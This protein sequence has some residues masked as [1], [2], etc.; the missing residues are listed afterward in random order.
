MFLLRKQEKSFDKGDFVLRLN[1]QNSGR[2][3]EK[4]KDLLKIL[5]SKTIAL[6]SLGL[7]PLLN[8]ARKIL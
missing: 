7:P 2:T 5:Q 3:L 6:H 4:F 8:A 1:F